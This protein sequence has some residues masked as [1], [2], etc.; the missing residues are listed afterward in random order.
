MKYGK[1]FSPVIFEL[2]MPLK[3]IKS[4]KKGGKRGKIDEFDCMKIKIAA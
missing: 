4:R 3:E 2:G 1:V